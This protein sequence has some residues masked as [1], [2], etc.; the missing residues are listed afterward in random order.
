MQQA[1]GGEHES[2]ERDPLEEGQVLGENY[3]LSLD[4]VSLTFTW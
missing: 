1:R 4:I 2:W 3:E